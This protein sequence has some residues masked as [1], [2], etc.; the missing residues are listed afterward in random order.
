MTRRCPNPRMMMGVREGGGGGMEEVWVHDA[1]LLAPGMRL[2]VRAKGVH[3]MLEVDQGL[4]RWAG[5]P[6]FA[7]R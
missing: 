2:R 1:S 3:G 7:V 6:M 4:P 5:D